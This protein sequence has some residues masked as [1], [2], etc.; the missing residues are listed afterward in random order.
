MPNG[1]D[2]FAPGLRRAFRRL[3]KGGGAGHQGRNRHRPV[4]HA[5]QR[6]QL[7]RVG[8]AGDVAYLNPFPARPAAARSR[9]SSSAAPSPRSR[10]SATCP[11]D[12]RFAV[13]EPLINI[14]PQSESAE[15]RRAAADYMD[16][17]F[18]AVDFLAGKRR[19]DLGG[20]PQYLDLVGINYYF[21]N[22]WV[23]HG[24]H[25]LHGRS[26]LWPA[27]RP[28][29]A[30]PRPRRAAA[31]HRRD[32]DRGRRPRARG[33][34]MSPTR[35]PRRSPTGCPVAGLCLYP[36]LSHVGWDNDRE[37]P[38]G[39]VEAFGG[40]RPRTVYAP[41]A[42]E[43]RAAAGAVCGAESPGRVNVMLAHASMTRAIEI[44]S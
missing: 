14:L 2:L 31:V 43:T 7:L 38:N 20:G 9:R 21:N 30:G 28:A 22:Q 15:H 44:I 19:P 32:R 5:G 33:S 42:D 23:D 39:M 34:T 17:Q 3:C 36:I 35:S 18:E 1:V 10:R 16:A 37:C 4:L 27:T 8:G 25:G 11:P 24:P 41:L 29:P 40:G 12:A 26:D 6:D 13:A